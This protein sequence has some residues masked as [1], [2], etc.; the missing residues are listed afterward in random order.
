MVNSQKT[1]EVLA[2]WTNLK[3]KIKQSHQWISLGKKEIIIARY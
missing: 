1:E 2:I 3:E